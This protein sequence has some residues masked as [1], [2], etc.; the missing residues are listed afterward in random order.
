MIEARR[1]AFEA[2]SPADREAAAAAQ[3]QAREN[4]KARKAERLEYA[5]RLFAL[6]DAGN[7]ATEIARLLGRHVS[8][9]R[10][11]AAARGVFISRSESIARLAG[12]VTIDARDALRR[13]AADY[14]ATPAQTFEDLLAFCLS[15]DATIARRTLRVTRKTTAAPGSA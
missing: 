3:K 2:L 8:S 6:H 11:F 5:R 10:Q 14:G 1:E 15:D 9:I 12:D 4:A 7:S 13:M